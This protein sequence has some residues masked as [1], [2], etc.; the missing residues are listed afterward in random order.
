MDSVPGEQAATFSSS[1]PVPGGQAATIPLAI[2]VPGEQTATVLIAVPVPGGQGASFNT[3]A[4]SLQSPFLSHRLTGQLSLVL[5]LCSSATKAASKE[6]PN[7]HQAT[8]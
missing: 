8:K 3:S 2:P 6:E 7:G 1:V 5:S 4:S